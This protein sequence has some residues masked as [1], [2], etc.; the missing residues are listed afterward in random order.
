V[1]FYPD[2][3]PGVPPQTVAAGGT[4]TEP[5]D[6]YN[7]GTSKG[8]GGLFVNP[9]DTLSD[10]LAGLTTVTFEGWYTNPA[11]TAESVYDFSRPVT[12]SFNLYA[13][14]TGTLPSG[15]VDVSGET[16]AYFL[17]RAL[18]YIEHHTS[19]AA[20]YTIVL[21]GG[22]Y[23]LPGIFND[24][25]ANIKTA[26]AAITLAGKDPVEIN[27]S[28]GGGHLFH[29]VAGE[30]VLDTGITLKGSGSNG[31]P[32][33]H[34][35]GFPVSFVMNA[36]AKI[37]GNYG[38]GVAAGEG[39]VFTMNGG[40]ISG[41]ITPYAAGVTV[42]GNSGF[43]MNGGE[44]SGNS[45]GVAVYSS[46]VF[47]MENGEIS[48]NITSTYGGG[49]AVSGSFTMNGGKIF[50]NTASNGGGGVYVQ[51]GVFTM[52]GGEIYSNTAD[53]GGAVYVGYGGGSFTMKTGAKIFNNTS[54]NAGSGDGGGVY[55]AGSFTM[56][57]GEI[58]GNATTYYGGGVFVGGTTS[59]GGVFTMSG[60]KI[61]GSNTANYGG[62]V[63]VQFG[64]FTM[65]TGAEISGNTANYGGGGVF[66][67]AGSFDKTGN[68]IIYASEGSPSLN[69]TA[70]SGNTNGHAVYYYT[71]SGNNYY[72]DI[73]LDSGANISTGDPLPSSS[74]VSLNNWTKQ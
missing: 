60:G 59:S 15:A 37:T 57:G 50:G 6:L 4:V 68:S 21:S 72:C 73:T 40:E 27:L 33:V 47:T 29:I 23:T 56:E 5:A 64:S 26:N 53:S 11:F 62:G 39:G 10:L 2:G 61:S 24:A 3:G 19:V 65:K 34:V 44:I 22:A 30:L 25:N 51:N 58:S 74:G 52:S 63:Y 54:G 20:N 71:G 8:E 49:V 36:G 69:N 14:W 1:T 41:N 18:A 66:V 45:G 13:K 35:T 70:G 17:A 32:L 12:S 28:P 48:G 55:V 42:M 7:L 67:S 46:G 38:G 16:G 43:I 31:G 9:A